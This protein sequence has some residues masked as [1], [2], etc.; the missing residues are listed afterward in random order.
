MVNQGSLRLVSRP[1]AEKSQCHQNWEKSHL[2]SKKHRDLFVQSTVCAVHDSQVANA[3]GS[4]RNLRSTLPFC[5][6]LSLVKD[7]LEQ[8]ENPLMSIVSFA[9][10]DLHHFKLHDLHDFQ[11]RSEKLVRCA[12]FQAKTLQ[13]PFWR[14]GNEGIGAYHRRFSM[15]QHVSVAFPS[16]VSGLACWSRDPWHLRW[17]CRRRPVTPCARDSLHVTDC[18]SRNWT[19]IAILGRWIAIN[20]YKWPFI[21]IYIY[22][23]QWILL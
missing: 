1:S 7:R 20:E 13:R 19:K 6:C 18:R 3:W 9:P 10:W 15:F 11:Q 12:R 16:D 17:S 4:S 8:A 22:D 14:R 21:Y 23:G 5:Q 2:T